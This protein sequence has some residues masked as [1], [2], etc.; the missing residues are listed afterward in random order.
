MERIKSFSVDHDFIKEG[1]Y[2]SRE[3]GDIVTYDLRMRV[4]NAGDY[5][6]N[7]TIHSL[8][9]MFATFIR[10]GEIK[11]S[12]IYFG[13]MGCRTGFYLIVKDVPREKVLEECISA[14]EKI[15]AHE[16]PVFGSTRKECGNYRELDLGAAKAEAARYLEVL[17][18]ENH[19][20][21]YP[22]GEK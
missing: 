2:I 11:E 3:Q 4:P 10:N 14:L 12:V 8:E 9:H 7:L 19:T 17:R 1:I 22:E 13:P 20:F 6:D 16:G 5:L 21:E 18:S 15:I